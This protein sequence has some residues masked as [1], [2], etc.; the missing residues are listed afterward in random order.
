M[1]GR[2]RRG[3]PIF[4]QTLLLLLASLVVTQ[5]VSIAL[6]LALPPPRAD[7]NR[8]SDV[9]EALAGRV[10]HVDRR[11][12]ALAVVER[13]RPPEP[14]EGMVSDPAFTRQLAAGIGVPA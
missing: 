13:P 6:L 10:T 2:P 11:E 1:I 3:L 7:F 5:L 12:R 9:A 14:E 4:W 8:L